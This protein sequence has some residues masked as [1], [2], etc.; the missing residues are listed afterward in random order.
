MLHLSADAV[1]TQSRES[2]DAWMAQARAAEVGVNAHEERRLAVRRV[3]A[4]ALLPLEIL[5]LL[6]TRMRLL[7]PMR[8]YETAS[9][10]AYLI[11]CRRTR[12]P[13]A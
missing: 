11:S 1:T 10:D 13:S 3:Q 6:S 9:M 2:L 7:P 8:A 5:S 4:A 12:V